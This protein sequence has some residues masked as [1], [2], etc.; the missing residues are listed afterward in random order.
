M[1]PGIGFRRGLLSVG[2]ALLAGCAELP[3]APAPESAPTPSA[4]DE[5]VRQAIARHRQLALQYKQS[6]DL[7]A[8]AAQWQVLTLLAPRDDSFRDELA[9]ARVSIARR[10]QENL[11]AGTA[12]LR[13]GDTD[14]AAEAMLKV[15]AL[16]PENAEAARALRD[17]EKR[18]LSR[19]QAGRAAKVNEAA[20][21]TQPSRAASPRP[22]ATDAGD[23]YS[24]EQPLEMFKAGDTAGGLRDLR[25][26]VDANPNDRAARQRIGT[27]V[28][29]RARELE[30]QGSREQALA[31][32]DQAVSLRGEAA[33]G[34]ATHIQAVRKALGD[35][36][37][38]QGVQAYPTD[39]ALAIK[40]WETSLRYDP[41]NA[42]AAARL[43][44]ARQA[45]EK[46][47]RAQK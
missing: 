11:N 1:S 43:R 14:R 35:E 20:A 26:F 8:A 22:P 21:A 25:R 13:S 6:G 3:P 5:Q 12:A 47:N 24:L 45:Q 19:I 31:L 2:L 7:F 44:D 23:A 41:Q 28:Y 33:P 42:R 15:L 40:Q 16:D 17:I 39:A 18:R 37:F 27:V 36:Y 4:H 10:A 34:W 29:D 46:P 30:G 38:D 32:Y 9:A